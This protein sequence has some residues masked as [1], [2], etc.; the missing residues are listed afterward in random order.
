MTILDYSLEATSDAS[1]EPVSLSEAKA[2]ARVVHTADD[3]LISRLI[4][5]AREQVEKDT[6]LAIAE[7][8]WRLKR[9]QFLNSEDHI[10]LPRVP[11]ASVQS[12]KYQDASDVQLTW[13]SA[14]YEVDA[15]RG[16]VLLKY[17]ATWPA[18]RAG[19]NAL[20]IN[21]TAGYASAAAVPELVNHAILLLVAHWYAHPEAE[22]LGTISTEIKQGYD[23]I[24]RLLK[25]GRYP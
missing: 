15:G 13:S 3:T 6:G 10:P 1:F 22:V 14:N 21:F 19:R 17:N 7:R 12:I 4:S 25:K 8:T 16:A 11:L 20:E 5:A 24:V 18:T 2:Q 9:D 23:R